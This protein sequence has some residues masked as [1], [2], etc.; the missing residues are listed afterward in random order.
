MV[1][2]KMVYVANAHLLLAYRI[3]IS[4]YASFRIYSQ[5]IIANYSINIFCVC[6]F[7]GMEQI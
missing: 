3:I 2:K 5:K 6:I 7:T 1:S 4:L